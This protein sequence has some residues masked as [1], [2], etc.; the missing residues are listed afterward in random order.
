[1]ALA[2]LFGAV[3][4]RGLA[5][6]TLKARLDRRVWIHAVSALVLFL[7]AY[8]VSFG[9]NQLPFTVALSLAGVIT[10]VHLIVLR[11]TG[12]LGPEQ[13]RFISNLVASFGLDLRQIKSAAGGAQ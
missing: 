7:L 4:W 3:S 11:L 13:L 5:V 12:E 6:R 8:V 10:F 2:S 1:M 9:P